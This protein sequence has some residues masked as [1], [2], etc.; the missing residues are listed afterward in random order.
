[1]SA[2]A[3]AAPRASTVLYTWCDAAYEDFAA[4]F[5]LSALA[6][7]ADVTVEI[8]VE[9]RD[10]Y[11]RAHDAGWDVLRWAFPERAVVRTVA[12]VVDGERVAAPTVRFVTEPA[13][14]A[15][16]VYLCDVD[17]LVLERGIASAHRRNMRRTGAPYSNIVR[18]GT[19]RLTGLHFCRREAQFPLPALAGLPLGAFDQDEV[20]LYEVVRRKGIEIYDDPRRFRPVPGIHLS[21]NRAPRPEAGPGGRR[22]PGWG[23][24]QRAAAYRRFRADPAFIA[25][26]SRLSARLQDCLEEIDMVVDDRPALARPW[27]G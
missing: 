12:P 27:R 6:H 15:A 21:P 11:L 22:I 18:P 23:I 8:G 1:V 13:T 19:R 26:R 5:A 10:A 9:D 20:V 2:A 3:K 24:E 17:L 7:N 25:L 4:L 16:F 14:P